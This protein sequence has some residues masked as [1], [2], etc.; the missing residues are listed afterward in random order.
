MKRNKIKEN[1]DK[2]SVKIAKEYGKKDKTDVL[3]S[4]TGVPED[5]EQPVQDADDL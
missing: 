5:K 1:S 2:L 4:Y 3:G